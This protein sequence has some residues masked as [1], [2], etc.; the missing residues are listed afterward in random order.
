MRQL[1]LHVGPTHAGGAV[2]GKRTA[3]AG[4]HCTRRF[5]VWKKQGGGNVSRGLPRIPRLGELRNLL[6]HAVVQVAAVAALGRP[7]GQRHFSRQS[8]VGKKM[9]YRDDL[10][11]RP[12]SEGPALHPPRGACDRPRPAVLERTATDTTEA[13]GPEPGSARAEMFSSLLTHLLTTDFFPEVRR[14]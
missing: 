5:P 8:V 10:L 6:A 4:L 7:Q 2:E 3:Q 1:V 14:T 13:D 12:L 9:N 11:K